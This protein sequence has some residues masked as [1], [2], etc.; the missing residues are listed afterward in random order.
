MAR[1]RRKTKRRKWYQRG[2]AVVEFPA[3]VASGLVRTVAKTGWFCLSAPVKLAAKVAS[4]KKK[5]TKKGAVSS[6]AAAEGRRSEPK[7][8]QEKGP[9]T[10]AKSSSR[11]REQSERPKPKQKPE[12]AGKRE[13]ST[14]VEAVAEPKQGNR[15][16]HG[17]SLEHLHL[18]VSLQKRFADVVG[19]EDAKQEILVRTILPMAH[20]GKASV[21]KVASTGG[22]LLLWGPPGNGKTLL[23]AAVAGEIKAD[24]LHVRASDIMAQAVG[25]AEKNI[26][27]LFEELRARS[28][29]TV[30]FLDKI[31]ALCPSRRRTS[32]TIAQRVI[33]E[34]LSQMDGIDSKV[35]S[36]AA[37]AFVLL[38]AATNLI[39]A[40]DP[41]LLRPGR[42]D[43][44]IYVGLPTPTAREELFMSALAER[45]LSRDIDIASLVEQTQ[46]YSCA[47]VNAVIEAAS[48]HA[49]LRCVQ[50]S[51]GK[52]A[53]ERSDLSAALAG[54]RPSVSKAEMTRYMKCREEFG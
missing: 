34:F 24:F 32:S 26:A 14:R 48:R 3:G 42:F 15:G 38:V 40:I 52:E 2:K 20:S 21:F 47:D 29:P 30:L 28:C 33:S 22:G 13:P 11:R 43:V 10:A 4:K 37:G 5:Q 17:K 18:G 7:S 6:Q 39:D 1:K 53:I 9:S 12:R 54:V 25:R 23:A 46:G 36:T 44:R 19:L 16:P 31:D 49:F 8:K 41:A 45:P 50:S 35:A 51:K 27:G